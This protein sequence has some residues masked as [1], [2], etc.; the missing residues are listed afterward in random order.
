MRPCIILERPVPDNRARIWF[1]LFVLAV[2]CLGGAG[3]FVVGRELPPRVRGPF[4]A[5]GF[6]RPGP[7]PGGRGGPPFARG[8]MAP[9]SPD[10]LN[11][12]SSELQLDAA[13]QDQVKKILDDRRGRLEDVHR[14][15]RERF[16]KEQRELHAAIRTVLRPDQQQQFDRFLDRR[17]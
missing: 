5:P 13:Q 10:L 12:L 2:F 4:S 16:E 3:G 11:R 17:R 1:S 15:A 7:M 8:P 9:L 14:E 6:G